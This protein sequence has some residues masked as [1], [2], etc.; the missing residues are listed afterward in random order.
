MTRMGNIEAEARAA[1]GWFDK[2]LHHETTAAQAAA[3]PTPTEDRMSLLDALHSFENEVV[4]LGED[5]VEKTAAI[6]SNPDGAE[7]LDVAHKIVVAVLAGHVSPAILT[8][9]LAGLRATGELVQ[10]YVNAAQ[11]TQAQAAAEAQPA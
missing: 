10:G 4:T 5:A 1:V 11:A 7:L 2:H 8:G 6:R 9:A 3:A